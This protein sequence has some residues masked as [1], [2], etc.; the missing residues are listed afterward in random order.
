MWAWILLAYVIYRL[1]KGLAQALGPQPTEPEDLEENQE[2]EGL[3]PDLVPDFEALAEAGLER[4]EMIEGAV[5]RFHEDHED[6]KAYLDAHAKALL[7]D[8][9]ETELLSPGTSQRRA[10]P[11]RRPDKK[12]IRQGL[13]WQVLLSPP[14][15][16]WHK[17]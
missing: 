16:S 1:I 14:P 7:D 9:E 4:D 15:S 17:K 6:F 10:S 12:K 13:K 3:S 8:Q 5:D 2:E 11:K